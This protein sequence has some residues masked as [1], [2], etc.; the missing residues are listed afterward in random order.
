VGK[1]KKNNHSVIPPVRRKAIAEVRGEEDFVE[2]LRRELEWPIPMNVQHL[3]DVV[4]PHD[5]QGDFGFKPEED[6]IAVSRL[7]SLT[8]DQPWGVFLFEFKTKRPYLSH[9][10]QL[11]RV[12]GSQRTLRQGDPIWDR[13]DLLFI[14]TPD[15]SQFQFVHFSG[16]KPESATISTFGWTGPDD[17]FLYTLCKHNLPRLRMPQPKADGGY[18]AEAWRNT[19]RDA[20]SVKPVTDEFYATLKEVFDA[21]QAGVKGLKGEDRRFFAELVVNRMVFLKFVEKKGWLD[22]DRDYLYH[23]FQ[24]H[25]GQNY[26]GN[27]L[28]DLFF[29]GLCKEKDQRPQRVNELL[30]DVP[31]LNAELFAPSDKWDDWAVK[32]ENRVFDLMFDKLLNPYAFTVCETSPLEAEVAF[33]QDLLGYGYEE[34]IADQHGQGAYYTHPTEVNLMCRESLRAFLEGRCPEVDKELIGKLVYTELTEVDSVSEKDALALYRALHDVTVV[35]PALGSGAFPMAMM[36]HLFLALRTLGG[37]LKKS[38]EFEKMLKQDGITDPNDAFALKLHII[39]RSIYGCDLDYFAVQIAKL[40]FW[41]E[42]MADCETPEALPNFNCKLIV[43]DALVSVVGT[44]SKDNLITLEDLLGHPTKSSGQGNIIHQIGKQVRE[45]LAAL[46][47]QYFKVRNTRERK[48]LEAQIAQTR[49][50]LLRSVGVQIE[51]IKRTDKHVLWQVDFAEIFSGE[52]PGFD[53][54]IA[55]PP[56][57]RQELIDGALKYFN[58][59]TTKNILH[60]LFRKIVNVTVGGQ[61]D[62]YIYFYLR[63]AMLCKNNGGIICFICSNS[64]LDATYGKNFQFYLLGP[65]NIR[66]IIENRSS[67]SFEAADINTII[68]VF[69]SAPISQSSDTAIFLSLTMPFEEY[70]FNELISQVLSDQKSVYSNAYSVNCVSKKILFETGAV[71]NVPPPLSPA[72][73]ADY[74]GGKWGGIYLRAPRIYFDALNASKELLVPLRNLV[75][76]RRG[77][78]TG[79]NEFFYVQQM[80]RAGNLSVCQTGSGEQFEI[81]STYLHQAI[82]N[83]RECKSYVLSTEDSSLCLFVCA[84]DETALRRTKAWRYV[85]WGESQGFH[86]RPTCRPREHWWDIGFREAWPLWWI[87]AHNERD[88]AFLNQGLLCGD[89]FF[90]ILP[91]PGVSIRFLFAVMVSSWVTLQRELLGR[92]GFGGG[93]LKT[94]GPDVRRL[95]VPDPQKLKTSVVTKVETAGIRLSMKKPASIHSGWE[96]GERAILDKTVAH[97]IGIGED[98]A[99]AL[100]EAAKNLVKARQTRANS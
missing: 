14:C 20:F 23:R 45:K 11:L 48:S 98:K 50:D 73:E 19:W 60:S 16:A 27:F 41:I 52:E 29:E 94:Q 82:K 25:G 44:D 81:E 2:L 91:N 9:L 7:L 1:P 39:E 86:N 83:T 70:D 96:D 42:L 8:E 53:I 26:W 76:L 40:R 34:L 56:Y 80:K 54:V 89:N 99:V 87:I 35:D 5:L 59:S 51:K 78:T 18:E 95:M 21:V 61:A 79:A 31:F 13:N 85:R 55:N 65:Y 47:R 74:E 88:G 100:Y 68:T 62:L 32:I 15:W 71:R 37:Y 92:G 12:L 6:R 63:A 97:I 28:C 33:N 30:G 22:D 36:K 38:S 4:I 57:L 10:R 69:V 72:S 24:A 3:A 66:L 75:S 58:L 43:G 46:K 90:E 49:D 93:L 64:W 67:R 77:Y 17:P 84:D